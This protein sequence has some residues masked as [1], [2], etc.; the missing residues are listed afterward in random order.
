MKRFFIL[1]FALTI[2]TLSLA[3]SYSCDDILIP[4]KVISD[5]SY[6]SKLVILNE[7]VEAIDNDKTIDASGFFE[8][9]SPQGYFSADASY[10]QKKEFSKR[11]RSTFNL[12][13][14][15]SYRDQ[16]A[17]MGLT[18]DQSEKWL[19]CV[20]GEQQ[21]SAKFIVTEEGSNDF[22]LAV[23]YRNQL[24]SD[25]LIIK[26]KEQTNITFINESIDD[27][28]NRG[29]H[30]FSFKRKVSN[31][32]A[33]LIVNYTYGEYSEDYKIYLQPFKNIPRTPENE[34]TLSYIIKTN[35]N[36]NEPYVLVRNKSFEV[37][38]QKD[39]ELPYP[40]RTLSHGG[41]LDFKLYVNGEGHFRG[42]VFY[43][44]DQ[45]TEDNGF[46]SS[47]S[48]TA[49]TKHGSTF[50]FDISTQSNNIRKCN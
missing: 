22:D 26:V 43:H 7:I 24:T 36:C 49:I 33:K 46:R 25:K 31:R 45:D 6:H 30:H 47:I 48:S 3:Q 18:D 4:T 38:K 50:V 37:P 35:V 20:T 34:I 16:Y 28:L 15:K 10:Y 12:S 5:K 19:T 41:P 13:E 14:A 21:F 27:S 8:S 44:P 11:A 29:I 39:K 2:P 9:I 17:F 1:L 23:F 42:Y 32:P 40:I